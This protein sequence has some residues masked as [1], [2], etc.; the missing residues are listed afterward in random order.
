VKPWLIWIEYKSL[1]TGFLPVFL[2]DGNLHVQVGD[3]DLA[4]EVADDEEAT[5][6]A[7]VSDDARRH[8]VFPRVD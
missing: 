1:T 5:Q 6:F 4:I 7:G 8:E 2:A 3:F